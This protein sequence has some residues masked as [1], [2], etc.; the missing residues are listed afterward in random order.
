MREQ[1]YSECDVALVDEGAAAAGAQPPQ[2][3]RIGAWTDP[4]LAVHRGLPAA[5][6]LS[7][8]PGYYPHYHH[9]SDTP[10]NVSWESVAACSRIAAGTIGAYARRVE[11]CA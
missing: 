1:G 7:I 2:R 11:A 10:D 6:L 9:P 3:W 4:I 8:G 5:S